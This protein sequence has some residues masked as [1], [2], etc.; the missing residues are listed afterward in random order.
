MA[1]VQ[2]TMN[3]IEL[4]S[5]LDDVQIRAVI[6]KSEVILEERNQ[7]RKKNALAEAKRLLKAAGISAKIGKKKERK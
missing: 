6:A 1:S 3:V 4:L 7:D 2:E 5:G